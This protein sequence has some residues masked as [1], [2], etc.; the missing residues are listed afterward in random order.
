MFFREQQTESILFFY[1]SQVR[2]RWAELVKS[3]GTNYCS[4]LYVSNSWSSKCRVIGE[5]K[6]QRLFF[7]G[8][9][10]Q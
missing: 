6:H 1:I 5:N 4:K 3:T 7:S 10:E 9:I 2:R 8:F